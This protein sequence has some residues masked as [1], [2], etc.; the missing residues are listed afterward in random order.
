MHQVWGDPVN[1]AANLI[2]DLWLKMSQN[3]QNYMR[4][5][6]SFKKGRVQMLKAFEAADMF[7]SLS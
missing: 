6:F 5:S 3:A 4:E 1:Q 2:V 7:R